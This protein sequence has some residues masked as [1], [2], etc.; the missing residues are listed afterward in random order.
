MVGEME[1][2]RSINQ[3]IHL[4]MRMAETYDAYMA[5]AGVKE[6][7][8]PVPREREQVI[9]GIKKIFGEPY[10]QDQFYDWFKRELK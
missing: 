6:Y 2:D 8:V 3:P 4:I 9:N 5:A 7:L 10:R 1:V